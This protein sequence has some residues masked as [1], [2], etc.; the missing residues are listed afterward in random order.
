MTKPDYETNKLPGIFGTIVGD[1]LIILF[2]LLGEFADFLGTVL[3]TLRI[4]PKE[5]KK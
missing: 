3:R 2:C 1:T 4:I 5:R